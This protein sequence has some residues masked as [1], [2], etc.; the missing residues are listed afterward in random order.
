MVVALVRVAGLRPD[1]LRLA[2]THRWA[3][4]MSVARG[5]NRRGHKKPPACDGEKSSEKSAVGGDRAGEN[6]LAQIQRG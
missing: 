2:E 3:G 6:S 1:Y 5:G 4:S